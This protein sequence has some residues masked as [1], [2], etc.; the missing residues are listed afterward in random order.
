MRSRYLLACLVIPFALVAASCSDDTD[1][2]TSNDTPTTAAAGENATETPEGTPAPGEILAMGSAIE[3]DTADYNIAQIA[4]G[5]PAVT[6]LTQLVIQA[7]LVPTL[8]DGGPFTVFA[9]TDEAFAAI[10]TT[11]L[12][13]VTED[14]P[15][16]ASILTQ[17]VVPG[18]YTASD[19]MDLAGTSLTTAAGNQLAVEMDGDDLIVGGA[20]VAIADI[21]ASNGVIHAVDT[22]I[23]EANG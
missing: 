21:T 19:L 11:T 16:L 9:P 10:D 1:S 7:G 18:T 12:N 22:V 17:H 15:G 5:T 23:L 14:I 8:R 20:T 2:S 4:A 13:S 3:G 6:T